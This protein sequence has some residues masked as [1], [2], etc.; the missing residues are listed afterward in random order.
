MKILIL[1]SENSGKIAPFILEQ[2]YALN[3]KGVETD[4]FTIKQKG[5]AGYLRSRKSLLEK[6][7]EYKPNLIHAHFGLSGL[8]ANLQRKVP[9]ITTYHGSDINVNQVF[10]FSKWSIRLSAFNIFVSKK[11]FEK[12]KPKSNSATIPCGIDADLFA[13]IDRSKARQELG[14]SENEKL[15]LFAGA[16]DNKVKN[17]ILAQSAVSQMNDVRLIELRGFKRDDVAKLMNAVDAC[18]MTSHTEGSPQFIKEAMACNC[19]IVSV[20]VG[21]VKDVISG[22]ENCYL[23]EYDADDIAEKLK[24]VLDKNQRTNGREKLLKMGLDGESVAKRIIEIY[25]KVLS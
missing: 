13:P 20:D 12:A 21:D 18:L 8:L 5:L 7:Q 1:C 25:E 9:V 24:L 14:F 23:A 19:P 22:V 11:N 16:F 10:R 17:G 3:K 15:V 4:Y 2:V 6:I